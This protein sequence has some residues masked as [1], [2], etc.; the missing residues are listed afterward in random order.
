MYVY[1][2]TQIQ[3]CL[4]APEN[5]QKKGKSFVNNVDVMDFLNKFPGRK[6]YPI[7]HSYT[8][9]YMVVCI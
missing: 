6:K 4:S 7:T 3:E 5:K 1:A 9:S 8:F 2:Y